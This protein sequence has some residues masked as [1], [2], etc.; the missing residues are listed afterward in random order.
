MTAIDLPKPVRKCTLKYRKCIRELST[1][2]HLFW[3][4][5]VWEAAGLLSHWSGDGKWH[6]WW[7][8]S[9]PSWWFLGL[10]APTIS[11]R[12]KN[13]S[14]KLRQ[15]SILMWSKSSITSELFVCWTDSNTKQ[16][17]TNQNYVKRSLRQLRT[18]WKIR[19][20]SLCFSSVF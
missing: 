2:W 1:M 3:L 19:Y 7:Y 20:V 6:S 10:W 12:I 4:R 8:H 9:C 16:K 13:F 15:G 18:A 11:N 17:D 5:S 14:K